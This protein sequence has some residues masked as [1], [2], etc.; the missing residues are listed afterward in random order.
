MVQPGTALRFL[1]ADDEEDIRYVLGHMVERMGH[2][3]DRARDGVEAVEAL[4]A[5]KYDFLLLDLTMP[6]MSGEDVLRWLRE[7]P[8]H[9][10]DLRVVVVSA[11]I[12]E[13]IDQPDVHAMLLK[14]VRAQQLRK[15][16]ADTQ[17]A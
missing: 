9:A 13:S 3:A 15:L 2:T 17:E 14:P 4:R 10:Q 11:R 5:E 7:H 6:R 12:M 1:V 16:I 8:E